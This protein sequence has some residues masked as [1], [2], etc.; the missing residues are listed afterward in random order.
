VL[1]PY[2]ANNTI[3][4]GVSVDVA[5]DVSVH[6]RWDPV[7]SGIAHDKILPPARSGIDKALDQQDGSG[8]SLRDRLATAGSALITAQLPDS[9][10]LLSVQYF[11]QGIQVKYVP[12]CFASCDGKSCGDDGC[13][14]SCG[15]CDGGDVCSGGQCVCVPHCDGHT[16]GDDGC[17][18]SCGSC[19]SYDSCSG[20]YCYCANPTPYCNGRCGTV[21]DG[22]GGT[23]NCESCTCHP[24]CTGKRCG[25]ADGCG[26]R[27]HGT[28]A[29]VGYYCDDD[30]DGDYYCTRGD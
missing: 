11:A 10:R 5:A 24:S 14:G 28:C 7:A 29:K 3:K 13:G 23:I 9:I 25:A 8:T 4:T 6:G 20:G 18:G 16:C 1:S 30:G 21:S 12:M 15:T 19:P 22:C 27:C 17:G 2:I 26:G